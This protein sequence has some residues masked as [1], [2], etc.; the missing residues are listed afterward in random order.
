MKKLINYLSK[1]S[2]SLGNGSGMTRFSLASLICL[3]MLT[4]GVGSAS[5]TDATA[6]L[7]TLYDGWTS[8]TSVNNDSKTFGT[9]FTLT[10]TK[11]DSPTNPTYLNNSDGNGVKL[12]V[13]KSSTKGGKITI[14]TSTA[15]VYITNV[16]ISGKKTQ[17]TVAFYWDGNTSTTGYSKS[18]TEAS[19]TQSVNARLKE[20]G[21]SKNG[22]YHITSIT[23]SYVISGGGCSNQVNITNSSPTNTTNGSFT[24]DK[25]GSQDACS[26]LS[27]VVTPNPDPHYH[28]A[29]VSAT[30]PATTGTAGAAVD[31]GD[32]TYT[33]TYS[34]NAKGNST[35]SVT[36]AEDTHYTV[37]WMKNGSQHTTTEVYSGEKPTFPSNPS[38]CDGT[39]T[40]FIGWTKTAWTGKQ[41][42]AY[43]DGLTT[44]AT[45]V[46][47]SNSTMSTITASGTV[48][49]AVFAK[50]GAGGSGN[51]QLSYTSLSL[52]TSY[53]AASTKAVSDVDF[54]CNDIMTGNS[55]SDGYQKIQFKKS[56]TGP[57]YIYNS[58]IL[59]GN[60]TSIVFGS[61]TRDMTVNFGDSSNPDGSAETT[62]CSS[63]SLTATPTGNYKYFKILNSEDNAA[64]TGTITINYSDVSYSDYLTTCCTDPGLAYGTAS[65]TKTYGAS[66]FTNPL[67]NSHSVGVTYALSSVSPA[68][69]VSINSSTGQVTINAAGSATVTASFA[70]NATYCADEASYTLTVNKADISPSLSYSSTTLVIG[71]NSSSPTVGGNSGSGTVTY[72][73]T[74][75]STSGVVTLNTSTG[76][77]TAAKEGT[78]TITAT[79]PATTNYNGGSATANFTVTCG[80]PSSVDIDGDYQFYPGETIELTATPTGGAGTPVTYQWKK[81]GSPIA[82]ATSATY[83]KN[84]ATASD[85]GAYTCIVQ[86]GSN[87][88][89]TS[90]AFNLKCMQFYLKNN[91]GEDIS[92]HALTKVDATHATLSLSLTG[93]TTYK[94]RVTDGCG[95][96]YGNS[97]EMTSSNCTNW[98]MDADADCR[99]TT[100]SKS[101]TY[102]FNFDFTDGLLGS[103][104]KVSVVY[105]SSNQASGKVI[106]W[107]NEV[108][109]W[110]GSKLWYRIGKS[111]HNSNTQLSKV[112]G[113]ANFYSVTTSQ[114]DGFEY[115]H[116]A[117]NVGQGTGNIFWTKDNS[118]SG[119]EITN[120]MGFEGAPVTDATVTVTPTTTHSTGGS[121]DNNNCEF[122][123]YSITSGVKSYTVT[124][125]ATN[126]TVAMEKYNND[127]GSS[128]TALASGGTVMPT[129]YVKVTVTPNTGYQFSSVSVTNGTTVTAA[130]AGTP[131]VYYITGNAT[132]TATCTVKSCT[133]NF[134]KNSG[135]GGDA[136]TTATYGS[137]MTTVTAPTRTGYTF[138]GYWDAETDNDGSGT[139]YYLANG[140]SARDWDKDVT[141]AQ[142]LYAKWNAKEYTI[143]LDREGASTGAESVTATY[144]AGTLAGWSAPSKTG[145]RFDGYYSGD[146][147]TGT[148]VISTSGVLQNSVTIEAVNWTDGSGHWVKD[149]G[150]TVYAKWTANV[151]NITYKD[152]G[153][154]AYSGNATAGVP[155][156]A[157]T[158]HTYGSATALVNGVKDGYRFDGWFTDASCTVSAGSSIGATAVTADFTLYA[159][160]TQVYTVTWSVNGDTWESGVV[161]GNTQVPSGTKVSALPTAPIKSDC[162]DSK[163]FVGW[164]AAAIDGTSASDPGGIFTT[165]AGSP[166]ISANTIF[167]AVFADEDGGDFTRVTNVATQIEA[168]KKVIMGY[169]AVANSGEIIPIQSSALNGTLLYTGT[170]EGSAGTGTLTISSMSSGDEAIYAFTLRAGHNSG[171]WAFEMSGD[172]A[173]KYL[174][175]N[176][177]NSIT[178]A[179]SV[180]N[181]GKTDFSIVLGTNDVATITNKWGNENTTKDGS[182]YYNYK[183]FSYNYNNGNPR[184]AI[185]RAT[186]TGDFVMYLCNPL[187]Y[188]NYVTTCSSCDA[189][190]TF[191]NTTP[192]VSDI[193]CTSA[194]L[195]ATGG[196]ATVGADGCHVSDYGFVIGTSDNP[197]I[198]GSGVEKLQV[199]TSDPTVGE[200]FSYDATGLTKGTHYYIRAYAINRHGTAYS[201]SQNFWTKDVSSIAITTAPTKTNYIVGE[202]F[203]ATG[204]VVTA[205]MASGTTEDVTSDVT[206]SSSALTAGTS[207]NFAINYT[208]CETEKSVNQVINVYTLTVTEGAN[209][210]YGTAT[211]SSANIV[212][213]TSLGDHKTYTVTVT[214]SN[215]TAVD[216]GDN[217]WSIINPTGNVTVR[218]DYADAVQVKVYYK[219]DGVTV[220]GLTQDVYQ[221]ETTTLPTASELATAMTAQSMDLPDDDYPNFVGWS[222]TEFSSQT[223]EPTIVSGTPAINAEKTYYAV[224]TNLG[225]IHLSADNLV[226]TYPST[227]KTVNV[228]SKDFKYHYLGNAN[229]SGT[230]VMQ[231]KK[232]AS[233]YGYIYNNDALS[234]ILRIEI[235]YYNSDSHVPV[236]AAS[237]AGTIAGGAL[238]PASRETTDPYVYTF[239]ASTSYFMVKGDNSSTYK[240]S[241]IDIYYAS[242]T[243]YYM[244]Q[245]CTRYTITGASTSGTAVT[246][247][248]LTSSANSTCEGKSMTLSAAVNAGYAFGGWKIVKT[249]VVPEADVTSTLL[250]GDN[251]S[252][253]TPAAFSMPAYGITVSATITE[254]EVT[255]WTW[256]QELADASEITIPATVELYIGQQAKFNLKTYDPADVLA[257]KK[258]YSADYTNEDLAQDNKAGAYY[259]TRAKIAKESTTLTL[260]STSNGEVQEVITIRI[261]ALPLV[262]FVDNI[263]GE[264][265]ADVVANVDAS[266]KRTVYTTKPTPTH[267]AVDDPGASYNTCERQHLHLIGWIESEWADA[268]PNAEPGDIT[269]A[270][271]G[272][273]YAAGAN[274]DLVAQNG[275]TFYAVWAKFE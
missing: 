163:V 135:T 4:V 53:E 235:G 200:D 241:Y 127:A 224:F 15:G 32:G 91:S 271:A 74:T 138:D 217:T 246:G 27:V 51:I 14:T 47:T 54:Y 128:T 182:N 176:G 262:H 71:N 34:A 274:I 97:G 252:S 214:S 1:K 171:Y 263:H 179:E 251:A 130:A 231:F 199:G 205:T 230:H 46:H 145:Y 18:Y 42:Q 206:Y 232:D 30:N 203:D 255:G 181:D 240:I 93:G 123:T 168:G 100:S 165:Q 84:N 152:Q 264:T 218:V 117:N 20:T 159:K 227:E 121:S 119:L 170:T 70:G 60:I 63:S 3:C 137:A 248:T 247:G 120:A 108:N 196:L 225:Q 21:G 221:S 22:Q 131:G 236:Y 169:E 149:G 118:G 29:T 266:E 216:N 35:I 164:R 210:S 43:V 143:T 148:L 83:T 233:Q 116:I 177:K 201:S 238:T 156:G 261:K 160:W 258:G 185:Y 33:I 257:G 50:A 139:Q 191:T 106:Y 124:S 109:K 13:T 267:S 110:N 31:N 195:T 88:A 189:D 81:G 41:N 56:S 75:E 273:Y 162:D 68:G 66:A 197:A 194:T 244:T 19:H 111:T 112:A 146:N 98:A 126:C 151:Y 226:T 129:Q 223:S 141:A 208:L 12:Y 215:A 134:D 85:A 73:I 275:K 11:E 188:S 9:Y 96:W 113:T 154:V 82:G 136:S 36:F 58:E 49:H 57:G 242:S 140:T 268:H 220:T 6:L 23:V 48:Y 44:D 211:N 237:A 212:N 89:T 95:D 269:G 103:E 207:Q 107:D 187:T 104:M 157:P 180:T 94:F 158:T 102:T 65:V 228:G 105:P 28:V 45:K 219:V 132:V 202:T 92:N 150:V 101:A 80:A 254:K 229:I 239:P 87:C 178:N 122:Y 2:L 25:T 90:D 5:A 69:C 192:A 17:G 125:S 24:L 193:D 147:G 26:A 99:V 77:V 190:A 270:G 78:A 39:S 265:F 133:V 72:A 61:T 67:T 204:M 16:S 79:I 76:V 64:Y 8:N 59:P 260:T 52:T 173:G 186:Q 115:W 198:G 183:I 259:V 243:V 55:G 209:D 114:Y 10:W 174:S 161:S 250:P 249:G 234:N 175:H 153:D 166:T 40:T 7:S 142:T 62:T 256:K 245:F 144:D 37:T 172:N 253:L 86:Y 38:S 213:I 167:Y 272:N 155:T 184:A 222:E